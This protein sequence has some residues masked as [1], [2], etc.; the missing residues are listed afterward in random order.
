MSTG[1]LQERLVDQRYRLLS[2]L[3][4][5][6]M[7]TVYLAEHAALGQRR[8]IKVLRED[9]SRH[10]GAMKRFLQEA[11]V[12]ASLRH[13]HII[14]VMDFGESDG[15]AFYV[16]EFLEGEDLRTLLRREKPLPWPRVRA[17][18]LQ[19]SSALRLA[20]ARQ[21]V[22]RDL[23]PGNCFCVRKEGDADFIKLLDFGIAK[24]AQEPGGTQLTGTGEVLGTVGYMALEQFFGG[25]DA[26]SDIYALGVM[27]Y[28]MLAG[29]LP[30]EGHMADIV[31]KLNSG[32]LP[33]P[34]REA[35]PTVPRAVAAFVA[36]AM[37]PRAEDRF[38][39]VVSFVDALAG[40]PEGP[41]AEESSTGLVAPAQAIDAAH[42]AHTDQPASA[43]ELVTDSSTGVSAGGESQTLPTSEHSLTR[44]T[45]AAPTRGRRQVWGIGASL[46]VWIAVI[47]VY[48]ARN[49]G[50]TL[51]RDSGPVGAAQ[52]GRAQLA[53][54]Q[55][56]T[57]TAP[58][59]G[60]A[61]TLPTHTPAES[62]REA[63]PTDLLAADR[64]A[65][66]ARSPLPL[67]ERRE[68]PAPPASASES[69][70][71]ADPVVV[72]SEV[73][74]ASPIP[75]RTAEDLKR[76]LT[77]QLKTCNSGIEPANIV[78]DVS[79]EGSRATFKVYSYGDLLPS[80]FAC[81]EKRLKKQVVAV[82]QKDRLTVTLP[83][84][85]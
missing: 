60:I 6:G 71:R 48:A 1:E 44:E 13:E 46:V 67:A 24:V 50:P 47:G 40:L 43:P 76:L 35:V 39:D 45:A 75:L 83:A 62:D 61:P 9:L 4:E 51:D 2:Q 28:E 54:S 70:A 49:P 57:E 65:V 23:K 53:E 64:E 58:A 77:S 81:V 56:T 3:G 7:G 38:Q 72:R 37:M 36:R 10:P 32:S 55:G 69:V 14:E 33:R 22:H 34:L 29:K 30:Y 84:T 73:K 17:I 82:R 27:M 66:S 20:H 8:A 80:D 25:A 16:M 19:V 12:V 63:V 21:I 52:T 78:V 11:R 42:A 79:P 59:Q 31:I 85:K 5:G 15:V 68:E 41:D 26:R 18:M 74:S